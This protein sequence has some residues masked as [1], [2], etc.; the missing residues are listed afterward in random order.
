M[1]DEQNFEGKTHQQHPIPQNVMGV[2]F[3]LIGG[4]TL[5]QFGFLAFFI[6]FAWITYSS[7]LPGFIKTPLALTIAVFGIFISIVPIQD[8][9][10]DVWVKNFLLAVSSPTE[11]V[12]KKGRAN[13]DIFF[14]LREARTVIREQK[15]GNVTRDRSE[16][17]QYLR[18]YQ[19]DELTP[20][21]LAENEFL[22]SIKVLQDDVT[23]PSGMKPTSAP[24]AEPAEEEGEKVVREEVAVTPT[25]ASE[26]N[27]SR[28]KVIVLP[29]MGKPP[30][31]ITPIQNTRTGRRLRLVKP[32]EVGI[33][34]AGE[35]IIL[36]P[37]EAVLEQAERLAQKVEEVGQKIRAAETKTPTVPIIATAEYPN[38]KVNMPKV[39]A[40]LESPAVNKSPEAES[41]EPVKLETPKAAEI[42]KPKE[43]VPPP[44][45]PPP[46]ENLDRPN[47]PANPVDPNRVSP[48]N[49]AQPDSEERLARTI[50]P[51]PES[52]EPDQRME[53]G[54]LAYLSEQLEKMRAEKVNLLADLE[55]Q[56]KA[57]LEAETYA[58]MAAEYQRRANDIAQQNSRLAAEMKKSQEELKKLQDLST[59]TEAEKELSARQIK[60]GERRISELA[61]EK[62]QTADSLINMQKEL[63][64]LRIKQRFT[65]AS[66]EDA[67]RKQPEPKGSEPVGPGTLAQK[68][69]IP[70]VKDTPNI[71]NGYVRG[72]AGNLIKNAVVI[73]KDADGSP[74]RALKTNELGQFAITT[75]VPNGTYSVETSS[76]GET[77]AIISVDVY[78]S[79][80]EP[81][82]FVGT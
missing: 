50:A 36:P 29:G 56:K 54:K 10:A 16:L 20:M 48:L 37:K 82:D 58:S 65:Q 30:K 80:L 70:F 43:P 42:S 69:P 18:T 45:V 8:R 11:R 49:A 79:V 81:L 76:L 53:A 17:N 24:R 2:E 57:R 68:K 28:E 51:Q 33:A 1:A 5:R 60:E 32:G 77:F 62:S 52:R 26:V 4:L 9:S 72:K 55:N 39:E 21:D 15:E 34:V 3:K 41:R 35:K 19:N 22:K 46:V 78:G 12:W 7:A 40:L 64:E 25:L 73:V 38:S 59:K 66:V 74:V 63:R 47:L 71:I 13:L 67:R 27:Y 6:I 61:R 44:D 75:A 31:F 14:E 23:L